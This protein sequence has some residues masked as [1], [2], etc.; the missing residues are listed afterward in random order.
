LISLCTP[1]AEK[2]GGL[3]PAQIVIATP[4]RHV[5]IK[6]REVAMMTTS[7]KH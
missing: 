7:A 6:K 5:L 3:D 1:I 2:N 4:F